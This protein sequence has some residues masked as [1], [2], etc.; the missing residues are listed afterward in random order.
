MTAFTAHFALLL[1]LIGFATKAGVLMATG[2]LT[3]PGGTLA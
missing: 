2:R 3:A 1:L